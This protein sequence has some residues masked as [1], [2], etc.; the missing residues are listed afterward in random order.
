M[1]SFAVTDKGLQREQNEDYYFRSD[2]PVGHL[3]NLYIVA[4]GMGGHK[5]GDI[6]S[7]E[8][9]AYMVDYIR[10]S[11]EKV[12]AKLLQE[13]TLATNKY[14]Y[15]QS[16]LQEDLQG[17]GTTLVGCTIEATNVYIINVGD[18]RFYKMEKHLEQITLDHSMVEEL[19]RGGHITEAE[20]V[21]YPN[22]NIITR[23]IGVD[24]TVVL[25]NFECRLKEG[26]KIL[27]C[28]DGL[29]RMVPQAKMEKIL[30]KDISIEV[31]GETLVQAAIQ[32]GGA[33]NITIILIKLGNEVAK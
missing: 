15:E 21:A 16:K 23:A 31:A 25:D 3:P 22:K 24:E 32:Q 20:R 8:A 5:A 17:M 10:Q 33:D 14:I 13:A 28:S 18:S 11:S 6:A 26:D 9:V 19:Y 1:K 29:N 27:L 2:V 7:R 4:D 30:K 12:C